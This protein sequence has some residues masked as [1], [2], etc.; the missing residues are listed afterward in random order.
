MK[1]KDRLTE[2][3]IK[4]GLRKM[5]DKAKLGYYD[6]FESPIP[7]P[8]MELV[9]D[10]QLSGRQDLAARAI[11]GEWDST[12]E[13]AEQWAQSPDGQRVLGQLSNGSN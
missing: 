12:R 7:A 3:L 1:T 13:E 5:A 10:F 11:N 6:D 4:E 2:M 9:K 8:I